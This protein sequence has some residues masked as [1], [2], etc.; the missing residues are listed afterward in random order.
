M[1]PKVSNGKESPT[2]IEML[3]NRPV[4][5]VEGFCTPSYLGICPSSPPPPPPQEQWLW[6][7]K[8]SLLSAI[9]ASPQVNVSH[10]IPGFHVAGLLLAV[11]VFHFSL[12]AGV[13]KGIT[14]S[15]PRGSKGRQATCCDS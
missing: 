10:P 6:A 8:G 5:A 11:C 12:G 14:K 2:D 9:G 3:R 7:L 4:L 13:G 1:C 15:P